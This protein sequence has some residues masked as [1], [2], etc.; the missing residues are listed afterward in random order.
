[1]L[2]QWVCIS[3]NCDREL[4]GIARDESTARIVKEPD[5]PV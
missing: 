5:W 2:G 1:M 4:L 3:I